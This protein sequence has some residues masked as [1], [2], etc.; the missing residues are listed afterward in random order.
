[1]NHSGY[2]EA[3]APRRDYCGQTCSLS[4]TL[5]IVGERWT[6]LIIRDAFLGVHR[7][8]DFAAHLGLPRAVLINRLK[9]LVAADVLE[10][11]D[12]DSAGYRLTEKGL[13]LWPVVGVLNMWGE[14]HY[15]PEGPRSL[16]THA[17][18]DAMLD[19]FGRCTSCNQLVDVHDVILSPGPGL[20]QAP[21]DADSVTA[22]LMHPHRML[23]PLPA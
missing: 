8:G 23:Q 9:S 7:F 5:E 11:A 12:D 20:E 16:L 18:D 14:Q 17:A 10:R 4:K 13:S 21:P 1:M 19:P 2:T 6:L 15:A 22:A 3:M